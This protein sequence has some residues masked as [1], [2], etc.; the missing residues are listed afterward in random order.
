[1]TGYPWLI[2]AGAALIVALAA[3]GY[4]RER[5]RDPGITTEVAL[6]VTYVIG[7][8]AVGR[9]SLAAG[10]AVV[11][12]TLLA[13][14]G[15]LHRFS[16]DLLSQSPTGAP[17]H[18]KRHSRPCLPAPGPGRHSPEAPSR[19][20]GP[21]TMPIAWHGIAVSKAAVLGRHRAS[22]VNLSPVKVDA[23]CHSGPHRIAAALISS[24]L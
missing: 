6:F 7:V 15:S 4:W 14:R 13:S 22:A 20:L 17:L 18:R 24:V 9:R 19:P 8:V 16:V 3:I 10:G 11:V 23:C 21:M 2:F 12:T 1:M 5:S